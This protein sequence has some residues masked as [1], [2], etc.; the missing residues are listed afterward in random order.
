M[1]KVWGDLN[2]D[3]FFTI[4]DVFIF[5]KYV[6]CWPG[7]LLVNVFAPTAFGRFFEISRAD[8]YSWLAWTASVFCWFLLLAI[9]GDVIGTSRKK[10]A[11]QEAVRNTSGK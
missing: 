2:R 4:T 7:N 11:N 3:G 9:I 1:E 8:Q 6:A 5:V 10:R